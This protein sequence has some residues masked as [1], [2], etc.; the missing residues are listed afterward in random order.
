[1]SHPHRIIIEPHPGRVTVEAGGRTVADSTHALCLREGPMPPVYYVPRGDVDMAS[2]RR[3]EHA[4][5]C[6]FKGDA[7]YYSIAAGDDATFENAAWTYEAP[8]DEVAAIK[9]HLAFDPSKVDRIE[10]L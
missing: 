3:T 5:H 1:M 9:D 8:I 4:T 10:A 6:P 7:G 2:L